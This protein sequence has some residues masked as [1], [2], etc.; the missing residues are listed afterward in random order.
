MGKFGQR[1]R[2]DKTLKTSV[3]ETEKQ[4]NR[5]SIDSEIFELVSRR[6]SFV[7]EPDYAKITKRLQLMSQSLFF[8]S[9]N[10]IKN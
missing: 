6:N 8:N 7:L 9:E 2:G 5:A 10:R 3:V 1:T 4:T